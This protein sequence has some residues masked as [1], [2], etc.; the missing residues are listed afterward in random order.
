MPV[1]CVCTSLSQIE[2][3]CRS[4]RIDMHPSLHCEY[5]NAPASKV[6]WTWAQT[7]IQDNRDYLKLCVVTK[8]FIADDALEALLEIGHV[9]LFVFG[10]RFPIRRHMAASWA[11][12]WH[13]QVTGLQFRELKFGFIEWV[14]IYKKANW[15][16]HWILPDAFAWSSCSSTCEGA[17]N[18]ESKLRTI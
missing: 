5:T 18:D 17:S 9:Y 12:L 6:L 11:G 3:L 14:D 8:T 10:Q 4:G 7:D 16:F 13:L 1:S 15:L 2:T